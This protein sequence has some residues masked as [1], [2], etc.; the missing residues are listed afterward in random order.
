MTLFEVRDINKNDEII[1]Y[2]MGKYIN[3]NQAI[4]FIFS[5]SIHNRDPPVEHLAVHLEN[6]QCVY[7]TE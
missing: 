3:S 2:Q 6:S 7:F 4:W 1:Q 5:F